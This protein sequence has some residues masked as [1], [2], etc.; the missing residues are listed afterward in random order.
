M[1]H[2]MISYSTKLKFSEKGFVSNICSKLPLDSERITFDSTCE[3][4]EG[5]TF[6]IP[7]SI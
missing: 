2:E 7:V 5:L 3:N 4:T 1:I 6:Y